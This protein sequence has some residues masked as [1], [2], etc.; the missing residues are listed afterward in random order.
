VGDGVILCCRVNRVCRC[1]LQESV[2]RVV[3]VSKV[4]FNLA[5]DLLINCSF[6]AIA[7]AAAAAVS[8]V[9]CE[10]LGKKGR[11]EEKEGG[12]GVGGENGGPRGFFFLWKLAPKNTKND[13]N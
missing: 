7:A 8:H 3:A 4:V 12:G 13:V 2:S 5:E 9:L 11:K 10:R 1:L 6:A